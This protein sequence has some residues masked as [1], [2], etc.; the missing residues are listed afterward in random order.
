MPAATKNASA[1]E[2]GGAGRGNPWGS[3]IYAEAHNTLQAVFIECYLLCKMGAEDRTK[4]VLLVFFKKKQH[5]DTNK[6]GRLSVRGREKR[7]QE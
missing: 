4:Y 5:D 7:A 3:R 6:N 1:K 2:R